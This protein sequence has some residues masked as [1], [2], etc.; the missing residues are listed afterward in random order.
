MNDLTRR[1]VLTGSATVAVGMTAL[2]VVA[3]AVS[4]QSTAA[5]ED[6]IE[7]E[8]AI[9]ETILDGHRVRLRAYNGQIPGPTMTVVPGQT[10]RIRLK[11]SLPPY[12]SSKWGGDHN[13]PHGLDATNLH[14]HGLDVLPHIF[15]PLGTSD[16]MAPQI[17]I[18]PGEQ[19]EYVFEIPE[20]HP[21]GFDFYHPH[22]HGATAVQVVSG[23]AGAIIVRGAIDEVPEIKAAREIPLAVQDIGLF[24]S[25]TDPDLWTYEPVQNAVWQTF[26]GYVTIKGERTNL[27]GGFSTGD[28]RLRYFLLNG[29]PFFKETHNDKPEEAISPVGTQLPV[30]RFRLAP[31]EVVR[32][33]MLN[34]SSD[35]LMPIVVD[36]H[37]VHQIAMD[38]VNFPAVRTI[39]A[40][41][42]GDTS[43]QILLASANRSD[44]LVKASSTPGIY[45]IRQLAQKQQFLESAEK[46]IAEIEVTGPA[47]DMPLPD[48]LPIPTRGYPLIEASEVKR[49]RVIE[50]TGNTP[51]LINTIVGGD[52][53]INNAIYAEQ[54]VPTVVNLNEAEEWHLVVGTSHHGG[55]E[56]HP[57]HIH[58]NSFEVISI[59]GVM[60]PPGT[61]QDTVWVGVGQTVV[62]RMRFKQW[63]GKSVYHC[64]ILPHEDVGM[65][66]NFLIVDATQAGHK[67]STVS[68]SS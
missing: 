26:G 68:S 65:M 44:F 24:P 46:V 22:K 48:K 52:Y 39:P 20:D 25:E 58:V 66:Q 19:K 30:Q 57:F 27:R 8:T 34:G 45:R 3:V 36:G 47:K 14:V 61:I 55:A 11:N 7:L 42:A 1:Q 33:R 59:N 43:E 37:D 10:L 16:P 67:H 60:V 63:T 64:H 49:I 18:G 41:S 40:R 56:G 12:D 15:E 50:F 54:E 13:V 38:G 51:A 6:W 62:I 32:F 21:P 2:P 35:N 53:L 28:Y 17:V 5:S 4:Q 9:K 29:E 23:L 31:G